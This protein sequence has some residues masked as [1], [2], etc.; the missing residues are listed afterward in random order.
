MNTRNMY[1]NCNKLK[2]YHVV[3]TMSDG[4]EY[5][6]IIE[7]VNDSE[8]T[9]LVGESIM[10]EEYQNSRQP[11]PMMYRRFRRRRFPLAGLVGLGLLG[12]PL[13]GGFYSPFYP[14]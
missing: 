10:S 5:D 12:Y 4:R 9:I 13:F 7:D 11:Y 3:L 1:E 8:V 14:F 2:S 6:G